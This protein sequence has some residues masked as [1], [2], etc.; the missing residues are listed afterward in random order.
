MLTPKQEKFCQEYMKTGNAS[1]A[2]RRAYNTK[3]MKDN[4]IHQKA[5]DMLQ[6]PKIKDK[7]LEY[8]EKI[9]KT[10]I[11]EVSE[12]QEFWTKMFRDE[13]MNPQFRLKGSEL[14]GKSKAAFTEKVEHSGGVTVIVDDIK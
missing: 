14:L 13:E 3:R 8:N 1:E 10:L 5:W 4:S 6:K 12:L 2:Y 7:M 11:A 9:E